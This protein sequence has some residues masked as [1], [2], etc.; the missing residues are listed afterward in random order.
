MTRPSSQGH[1]REQWAKKENRKAPS[2][3]GGAQKI[4]V[5][6]IQRT[7]NL[8]PAHGGPEMSHVH[9]IALR[10]KPRI[11]IPPKS[12]LLLASK[13]RIEKSPRRSRVVCF[14]Q[15]NFATRLSKREHSVVAAITVVLG[16]KTSGDRSFKES[17]FNT[18]NIR[19]TD[20]ASFYS[21]HANRTDQ[22]LR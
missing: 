12:R 1:R 14:R 9:S 18:R 7:R 6:E 2:V 22:H 16:G 10:L 17:W 4:L 21:S 20:F 5:R 19:E 8:S 3:A 13:L 15:F 11:T